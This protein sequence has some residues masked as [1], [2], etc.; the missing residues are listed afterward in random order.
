[1]TSRESLKLVGYEKSL[2]ESLFWNKFFMLLFGGYIEFLLSSYIALAKPSEES[3]FGVKK[4][5]GEVVSYWVSIFLFPLM[6]MFSFSLS[7][8]IVF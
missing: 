3:T 8:W 5:T 2:N 1:M 7:V 4:L 6:I